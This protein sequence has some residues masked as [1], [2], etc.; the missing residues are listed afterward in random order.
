MAGELGKVHRNA[1]REKYVQH[2]ASRIAWIGFDSGDVLESFDEALG[3]KETDG[4]FLVMSRRSHRDAH[5][6]RIDLNFQW[7]LGGQIIGLAN[8]RGAGFP[9]QDSGGFGV[10]RRFI[11]EFTKSVG[12]ASVEMVQTL[13]TEVDFR[14]GAG[15]ASSPC[16]SAKYCFAATRPS[17]PRDA[18]FLESILG[19]RRIVSQANPSV[20]GCQAQR[21]DGGAAIPAFND[22]HGVRNTTQN[23]ARAVLRKIDRIHT[24]S[25]SCGAR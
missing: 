10:Q 23:S 14:K 7:L 1:R 11:A 5:G 6:A 16:G 21:R 24:T 3:E 2:I 13:P 9:A 25:G 4:K 8:R 15:T 20:R 18:G 19:H 12:I 22:S 17:P